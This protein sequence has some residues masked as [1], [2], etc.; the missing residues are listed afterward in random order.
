M[1]RRGDVIEEARIV[2]EHG[3]GSAGADFKPSP[4]AAETAPNELITIENHAAK[5]LRI[6]SAPL[7]E[8]DFICS[9]H[10]ADRGGMTV[11][12][13]RGT[14][15]ILLVGALVAVGSLQLGRPSSRVESDT[16]SF[17]EGVGRGLVTATVVNETYVRNGE[18]VT[19]PVG[20]RLDN[21]ADTPVAVSEEA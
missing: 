1:E 11:F 12:S 3:R 16:M 20:I 6:M 7:S 9:I 10:S 19:S 18:M 17:W 2:D 8:L 13:P 21:A 15:V 5:H 14:V 4:R